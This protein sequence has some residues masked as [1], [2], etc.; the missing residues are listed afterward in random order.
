MDEQTQKAKEGL[1]KALGVLEGKTFDSENCTTLSMDEVDRLRLEN[2]ILKENIME[3]N[4]NDER[5]KFY[6]Y[7][8]TKYD[9]DEVD[10]SLSVDAEKRLIALKP[11]PKDSK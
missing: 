1:E 6:S 5:M 10:F 2:L 3:R 9:I 11:R 4:K 7:I 8:V